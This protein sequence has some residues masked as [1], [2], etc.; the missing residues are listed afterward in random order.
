M[1]WEVGKRAQLYVKHTLE[2]KT[3]RVYTRFSQH[4]DVSLPPVTEEEMYASRLEKNHQ[5]KSLSEI[6]NLPTDYHHSSICPNSQAPHIPTSQVFIS[7]KSHVLAHPT[8]LD[9]HQLYP[10]F[11]SHLT[12]SRL[13]TPSSLNPFP[14]MAPPP[15]PIA[16]QMQ[17][18]LTR[19][20][21]LSSHRTL[22]TF[23]PTSINFSSNDFLSLSTSSL[24]RSAYLSEL[25]SCPEEEFRIGSGGSR[26]LDG[27][28]VYAE[29][30]EE[31]IAGFHGSESALLWNSG[32]DANEGFFGYVLGVV[33]SIFVLFI[34]FFCCLSF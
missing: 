18:L 6:K 11:P 29:R 16:L 4:Q 24:F 7:V 10:D 8:I 25:N 27:N 30:L 22:T 33:V 32:F 5:R 19:R 9:F 13:F 21:S 3:K 23:P 20:K 14:K 17:A 12:S 31:E 2:H 28:S 34:N 1:I 15:F 26:L